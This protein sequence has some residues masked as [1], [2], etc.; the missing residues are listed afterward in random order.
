MT[1][2][3]ADEYIR[4][5]RSPDNQYYSLSYRYSDGLQSGPEVVCGAYVNGQ[6]FDG[7]D[8]ETVITRAKAYARAI[9]AKPTLEEA[10]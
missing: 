4:A 2:K 1:F 9:L 10:P 5:L 7:P 6:S 8:W 3:R